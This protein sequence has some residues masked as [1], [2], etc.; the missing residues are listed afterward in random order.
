MR[1]LLTLL[2][3]D[4]ANFM[5]DRVA[6]SLTFLVPIAL[7]YVFGFVFGLT[8]KRESG[9]RG[10][11]LA[12]VNQSDNPAA[13]RLVDALRAETA[14]RVLATRTT[15]EGA[16]RP[17]VEE[18][19]RPMIENGDYRFAVL[20]PRD[21]IREDGIGIRI[22]ILSNPAND[23]EAQMV[24]GLLQKTIFSNVPQLLGQSLQ[25]QAKNAIG[26]QRLNQFN[27]AVATTVAGYFDGDAAAI[28]RQMAAGDFGFSQLGGSGSAK[29][30][31]GDALAGL[32]KLE[33]EQVVGRDV[34]SPEATRVVGGWAIM[35]LLF[36]VSNSAAAFFEEKKTG[37]FQRLLAAPLRRSGLLW[38]RFLWGV[39]L[40]VV[41]LT[42]LFL[43][44]Q[45]L[46]GI[47]VVGR[48]PNLVIVCLAAAAACSAFGMLVAALTPSAGAASG[49]STFLVL[50]MSACGGAWFPISL[51]PPFMQEAA[52]FTLV[53]WAMDGFSQVLWAGRSLL[54]VLPTV[55]ML[56]GIA[57]GVMGFAVWR[58]NRRQLFG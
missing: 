52:K 29:D 8:G 20:I 34:K 2:R 22:R 49:L 5:R 33:T 54:Q 28:E 56:L 44:G 46:Y 3:K 45:V 16:E 15:S 13:A 53:Y 4:L 19:L 47:E 58:F 32:F 43:A 51:M 40:G 36:A 42:V 57:G 6:F 31:A 12:V 7:I 23:I 14:F 37:I 55:G 50:I 38:S 24:N 26:E 9:P 25:L 18:D 35:F 48:L 17:L 21:L 30:G 10:I 27:R 41:Q 1:V 11:R 39:L